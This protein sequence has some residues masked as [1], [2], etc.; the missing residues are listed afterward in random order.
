MHSD[1]YLSSVGPT[2]GLAPLSGVSDAAFRR[3]ARR[4]GAAF[5]V[6]EMVASEDLIRGASDALIR[7]EASGTGPHIV[8]L[9]GRRPAAMAQ[10]AD[11]AVAGGADVI[12]IN[13]GCPA[14]RVTGGLAGSALMREEGLATA[15]VEAVLRAVEV[16]VTVKMRLGWDDGNRNAARLAEIFVGLGVAGLA[17][18]GRT[19]EQFY[20]GRADWAAIRR[21]K[22]AVAVPVT[23]NGDVATTADARACLAASGADSVMIGRAAVGQPWLVGAIATTLSGRRPAL[24]D[25]V[26]RTEIAIE[27]YDA[28]LTSLGPC[29]GVR[30]AR[31]HLAAYVDRALADGFAIGADVRRRLVTADDPATVRSLLRAVWAEPLTEA[32]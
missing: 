3:A 26:E 12:D 32:A 6:T 22:D 2:V 10:A 31:K 27:H 21:V 9:V 18:H 17:V 11:I 5:V 1:A 15:I 8:Q 14:K 13:M 19:R 4:W 20:K 28:L 30:H 16:R 29:A 7:S 23:A 24:P 25:A